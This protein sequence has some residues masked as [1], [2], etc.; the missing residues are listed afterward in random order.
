MPWVDKDLCIG[1]GICVEECPVNAIFLE[2]DKAEID[3]KKC[4]HCGVCHDACPEKAVE[5]DSE[6]VPDKVEANVTETQ[7]FMEACAKYL[8]SNDEKQ[9]CL[10][11]MLKHYNNEKIIVE[12]TIEKLQKMKN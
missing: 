5:H 9:K 8:G 7:E 2:E 6:L 12:K 11:R 10:T 1:C 4:I 3:M